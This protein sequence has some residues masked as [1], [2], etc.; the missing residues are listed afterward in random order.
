NAISILDSG[1]TS[2]GIAYLTM[3]LL[4][5][6]TLTQEL[7]DKGRLSLC[8]ATEILIPIC[9][10]LSK[11]HTVGIVHRDIKPDNIFLHQGEEGEVVKVVDFGIAK[12]M[13]EEWGSVAE[14]LTGT[15]SFIGTPVYMASERL[16]N[17]PYDGK[18]DVYSLGVVLYE[19]LCGQVPFYSLE[20]P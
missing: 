13:G 16:A 11:A 6:W 1:V 3:E 12:L 9:D 17:K 20:G 19:M 7:K 10:V 14:S 5:G 15:G 2:G 8:R 4:V 18:A